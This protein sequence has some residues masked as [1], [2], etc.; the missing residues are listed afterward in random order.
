VFYGLEAP[1][2]PYI[3]AVSNDD[4]QVL[5]CT[6]VHDSNSCSVPEHYLWLING[7]LSASNMNQSLTIESCD[8]TTYA[9]NTSYTYSTTYACCVAWRNDACIAISQPYI[10]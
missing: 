3:T 7:T 4:T 10:G 5:V 2:S 9:Y 8:D 1:S 6:L